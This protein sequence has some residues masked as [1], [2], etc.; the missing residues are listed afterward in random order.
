MRNADW[1]GKTC[2]L[3][4][5]LTLVVTPACAHLCAARTCARVATSTA[6]E[7]LC[8]AAKSMRGNVPH[9]NAIQNCGAPELP[10]AVLSSATKQDGWQANRNASID[11]GDGAL[12][13][14]LSVNRS[15]P[16]EGCVSSPSMAHFSAASLFS[17]VLRI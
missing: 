4:M 5:L 13:Q 15:Q 3:V 10:A 2:A 12:P 17:G 6:P 11:D 14:E 16:G 1:I 7:A 8:H 9:V